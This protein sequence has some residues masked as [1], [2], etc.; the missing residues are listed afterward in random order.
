MKDEGLVTGDGDVVEIVEGGGGHLP[1]RTSA[2][3]MIRMRILEEILKF[4]LK[5]EPI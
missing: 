4:Q 3:S 1:A 5:M 2:C